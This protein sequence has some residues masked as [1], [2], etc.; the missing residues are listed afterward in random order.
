MNEE[1]TR[2]LSFSMQGEMQGMLRTAQLVKVLRLD[3][4]AIVQIPDMPTAVVGV[5]LW[6][7]AV[8]WLIDL[9]YLLGYPPIFTPDY[10]EQK[11][12][13]I[14]VRGETTQGEPLGILVDKVGKVMHCQITTLSL[15][16]AK[17]K[18]SKCITGS[19]QNDRGERWLV[20]DPGAI[21]SSVSTL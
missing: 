12:S 9:G 14:V 6:E 5:C 10:L 16:H 13:V 21:A 4:S 20:L 3:R 15:P 7:G 8:L 2:F 18:E 19:W 11:C 1:G 17:I